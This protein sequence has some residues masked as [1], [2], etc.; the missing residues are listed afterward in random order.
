MGSK[1]ALLCGLLHILHLFPGAMNACFAGLYM[2]GIRINDLG[3]NFLFLELHLLPS[4][5][6]LATLASPYACKDL[7]LRNQLIITFRSSLGSELRLKLDLLLES[8][9]VRV[10]RLVLDT[11]QLYRLRAHVI[12]EPVLPRRN[13]GWRWLLRFYKLN[14]LLLVILRAGS[15]SIEFKFVLLTSA[16]LYVY[17]L[18]I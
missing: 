12:L 1:G 8:L 17:Q 2:L 9:L 16:I 10:E 18:V 5:L 14:F 3:D 13:N 6:S 7:L 4:A 15:L 11:H